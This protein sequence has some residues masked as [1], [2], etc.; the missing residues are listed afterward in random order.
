M[1]SNKVIFKAAIFLLSMAITSSL[2]GMDNDRTLYSTF[3]LTNQTPLTV[4]FST[5]DKIPIHFL[6]GRTTMM[7]I[8]RKVVEEWNKKNDAELAVEDFLLAGPGNLVGSSPAFKN[9]EDADVI[10]KDGLI[11][12]EIRIITATLKQKKASNNATEK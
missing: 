12:D 8:K 5:E 6:R 9:Y 11:K 2:L 4:R 1:S 10:S 7:D 3:S